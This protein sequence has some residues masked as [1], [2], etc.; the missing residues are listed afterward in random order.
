LLDAARRAFTLANTKRIAV[1]TVALAAEQL[2]E[3]EVQM[4]LW[5]GGEAGKRGGGEAGKRGSGGV[6]KTVVIQAAIDQIRNR[7]GVPGIHRGTD[8]SARSDEGGRGSSA[9]AAP[10]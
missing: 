9:Q 8:G 6:E 2:A 10:S 4:E 1:R 3:M 7:W 5:D